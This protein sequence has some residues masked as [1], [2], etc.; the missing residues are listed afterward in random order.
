MKRILMVLCVLCMLLTSGCVCCK[1]ETPC[2]YGKKAYK[3]L[4]TVDMTRLPGGQVVVD[5]KMD[6]SFWAKLPGYD[7]E[8]SCRYDRYPKRS[9]DCIHADPYEKSTVKFAYDDKYL[10]MAGTV[11]D[12]DVMQYF[13]EKQ[14]PFYLNGDLMEL[15]LRSE[16]GAHYWEIY[17]TPNAL[18][19]CYFYPGPGATVTDSFDVK[20]YIHGI[21][22]AAVVDGTFNNF[23]DIDKG[24]TFE[25]AIPI[26][27][28]NAKGVE[29]KPGEAWTVFPAR[30]NFVSRYKAAQLSCFPQTPVCNNHLVDYY[31]PVVFK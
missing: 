22:A 9:F 4:P 11:T 14:S 19:T 27:D 24:W 23:S 30:Y 13:T 6:E 25:L 21:K 3:Q 7:L 17:I 2:T 12:S 1:C 31:A 18:T 16:S 20:H 28:I 26:A 10:Y 5:G 8:V 15:F 29:F